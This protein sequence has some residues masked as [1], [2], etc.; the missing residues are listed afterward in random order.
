[1][2]Y[3]F[4]SRIRRLPVPIAQPPYDD[5][6]PTGVT[7]LSTGYRVPPHSHTQGTLALSITMPS[8]LPAAPELPDCLPTTRGTRAEPV[9]ED[10]PDAKLWA[11]RVA[12]AALECLCGPRPVQQL[13]RWTNEEV[14]ESLVAI[15]GKRPTAPPVKGRVRTVITCRPSPW[16][17]EATVVIE[18]GPRVRSVAIRLEADEH[19]WL[20]TALDLI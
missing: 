9:P 14:Y 5:E 20:C 18:A 16:V 2:S 7:P 4:Q 10:L 17:V 15:I 8:G 13:L 19:R 11:A 6:L 3:R 1:M 12:Q